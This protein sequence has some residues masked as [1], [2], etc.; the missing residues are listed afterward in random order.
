MPPTI[1]IDTFGEKQAGINW[2]DWGPHRQGEPKR[3]HPLY[4]RG[5]EPACR[6]CGRPTWLADCKGRPCH[7]VCAEAEYICGITFPAEL[8]ETKTCDLV[9]R[10][11]DCAAC[12]T[13]R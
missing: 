3:D 9:Y 5:R 13:A 8:T 7:K 1:W 11:R 2:Q 6:L 4:P 10:A 12:K